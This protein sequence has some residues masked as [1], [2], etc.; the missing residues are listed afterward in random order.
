MLPHDPSNKIGPQNPL[1]DY[2]EI[3][4]PIDLPNPTHPYSEHREQ[5]IPPPQMLPPQQAY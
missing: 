4:E 2:I 1:P 3:K 5:P